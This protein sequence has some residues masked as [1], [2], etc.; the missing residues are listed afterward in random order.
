MPGSSHAPLFVFPG[1]VFPGFFMGE[2]ERWPFVSPGAE[3]Y[4]TGSL[5]VFTS[6]DQ[7]FTP[8]GLHGSSKN[9]IGYVPAKCLSETQDIRPQLIVGLVIYTNFIAFSIKCALID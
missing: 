9:L 5:A 1:E 4:G 6:G 8:A 2:G 7:Y 3:W